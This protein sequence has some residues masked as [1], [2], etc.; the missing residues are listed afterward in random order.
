MRGRSERREPPLE[1]TG[2]APSAR[3]ESA[4]RR[5]PLLDRAAR[6]AAG[7]LTR[8]DLMRVGAGAAAAVALPRVAW[9]AAAPAISS[10][11]LC[12]PVRRGVCPAGTEAVPWRRGAAQ[13]IPSGVRATFNGCGAE[14]GFGGVDPITDMPGGVDFFYGCKEHDCCYGV[15]GADKTACDDAFLADS[16]RACTEA[17]NDPGFDPI[18]HGL[19]IN[20]IANAHIY[21]KGVRGSIGDGALEAAQSEACLA[22]EPRRARCTP[23]AEDCGDGICCKKGLCVGGECGRAC[24]PVACR[25][26]QDCCPP[27]PGA[28]DAELVCCPP[29]TRC[30][31]NLKGEGRCL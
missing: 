13:A 1:R 3:G 11:G 12:P 16:L 31:I 2:G 28:S 25:R 19:R 7:G 4:A 27:R 15:C 5:E 9:P 22:C 21:S 18:A 8:R 24:G 10:R 17:F 26:S 30:S 29:G 14:G 6:R 20:C 23:D